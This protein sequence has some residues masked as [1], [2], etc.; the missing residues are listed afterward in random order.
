MNLRTILTL[1]AMLIWT[2]AVRTAM[3]EGNFGP[4]HSSGLPILDLNNVAVADLGDLGISDPF[5]F[6]VTQDEAGN[7][8]T[9]GDISVN[10][11]VGHLNGTYIGTGK[12]SAV[13]GAA[14]INFKIKITGDI[15]GAPAKLNIAYK[16]DADLNSGAGVLD[17]KAKACVK[18]LGCDSE[19]TQLQGT[20]PEGTVNEWDLN[21]QIGNPSK[22]KL[23]GTATLTL[24]NGRVYNFTGKGAYNAKKDEATYTITSTA[25]KANKMNFK[26]LKTSPD[27]QGGLAGDLSFKL[28]RQKGQGT[29]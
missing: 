12:V 9:N 27:A 4:F 8:S 1:A 13:D 19:T 6:V 22:N 17:V 26:H 21:L 20:L 28:S 24:E 7:L 15:D 25:E 2:G 29:Q 14:K 23:D 18:G 3:P 5:L 16:G 11:V 10:T